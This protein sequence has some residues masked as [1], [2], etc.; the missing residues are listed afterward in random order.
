MPVGR[1]GARRVVRD[2]R[3]GVGRRLLSEKLG[4][5]EPGVDDGGVD[6]ERGDLGLQRLCPPS[7]PNLAAPQAELNSKPMRPAP[8]EIEMTWPERCLRITGR[9]ARV[10]FI[11]P[12]RLVASCRSICSGVSSSK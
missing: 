6:A 7:R 4:A 9:T 12:M 1:R 10:T 8:D 2:R 3:L 11:G 5:E